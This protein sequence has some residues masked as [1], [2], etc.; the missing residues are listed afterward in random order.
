[1]KTVL[2]VENLYKNYPSFK[3]E[4]VSF[5]LPSGTVTGFIGRNGAGKTTTLKGILGLIKPDGGRVVYNGVPV[6]ECEAAFKHEA[7]YSCGAVNYY[8]KKKIR[9][10]AAVT[11]RFYKNF[12]YDALKKY[13]DLFGIDENKSPSELSEGMKVKFN[14]ALC[15]SHGAELLILD[16]PTSGLDPVSRD[17]LLDIFRYLKEHG[18]TVLFSTHITTDLE[19]CADRIVY[20]KQGKTVAEA[21]LDDF[22]SRYDNKSLEDIMVE[23]EREG[24]DEKFDL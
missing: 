23:I 19:K 17:E 22:K 21:N 8:V 18:T 1:M 15:L 5:S 20:I 4:N 11:A 12:D 6:S 7:G 9:D 14:L 13:F 2:S 24:K 16:E 3:L 10:I